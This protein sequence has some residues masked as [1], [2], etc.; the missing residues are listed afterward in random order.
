VTATAN[1]LYFAG[2]WP[3]FQVEK[4]YYLA[5]NQTMW[6]RYEAAF[7]QIAMNVDGVNRYSQS[8]ADW[9]ITTRVD[10][11]DQWQ[12]VLAAAF[13][14]GSQLGASAGLALLDEEEHRLLWGDQ[15]FY[16]AMSLVNG[17]RRLEIDLF[18]GI[19][20]RL[21]RRRHGSTAGRSATG[22]SAPRRANAERG[23]ASHVIANHTN[24]VVHTVSNGFAANGATTAATGNPI[25]SAPLFNGAQDNGSVT[26]GSGVTN[27]A[28]NSDPIN[29]DT[30]S[31]ETIANRTISNGIKRQLAILE[32][33][34]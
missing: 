16:R 2:P 10:A 19:R 34:A 11:S 27:G 3:P 23:A 8:W 7:G 5:W 33:N 17:G 28:G 9:A 26:N 21:A 15:Q 20:S 1:P 24:T 12:R 13:C 30:V 6:D 29:S 32:G 14:H 31:N 18:E 25:A 4:L 22:Q